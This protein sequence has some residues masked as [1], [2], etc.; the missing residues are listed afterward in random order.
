MK[1]QQPQC[2][3]CG[4]DPT[5]TVENIPGLAQ[6]TRNEDGSFDY[7]GDTEMWWDEGETRT[8]DQGRVLLLCPDNHDWWSEVQP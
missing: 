1:F 3:E 2:P 8:D 4:Q 6:L 7:T 5:G